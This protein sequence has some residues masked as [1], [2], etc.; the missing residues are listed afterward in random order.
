MWFWLLVGLGTVR[1]EQESCVKVQRRIGQ[2][3]SGICYELLHIDW[4][5]V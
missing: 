5:Q 1:D 4:K 2:A 3:R